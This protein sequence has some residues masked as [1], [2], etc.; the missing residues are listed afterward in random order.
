MTTKLFTDQPVIDPIETKK[1]TINYGSGSSIY[2]SSDGNITLIYDS[3]N[4]NQFT[5]VYLYAN[6]C[7]RSMSYRQLIE[8]LASQ[9]S[10]QVGISSKC[11]ITYQKH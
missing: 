7:A 8:Q 3:I 4:K 11:Q 1:E 5:F 2:D 6:W 10:S 9:H